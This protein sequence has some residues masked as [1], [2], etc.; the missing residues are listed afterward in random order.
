MKRLIILIGL[1][2]LFIF[3]IGFLAAKND[4][5]NPVKNEESMEWVNFKSNNLKFQ[6]NFPHNPAKYEYPIVIGRN[7]TK[8]TWTSFISELDGSIY[9]VDHIKLTADINLTDKKR[10]VLDLAKLTISLIAPAASN[11]PLNAKYIQYQSYPGLE[12][13]FKNLESKSTFYMKTILANQEV[14][15]IGIET[16]GLTSPKFKRFIESFT[17][18]R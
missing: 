2:A 8:T 5:A 17:L 1:T 7:A 16:K 4:Q 18:I 13:S 3:A 6:A 14:F 10:S 11:N 15:T 12:Y 9:R